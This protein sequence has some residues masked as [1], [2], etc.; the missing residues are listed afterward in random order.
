MRTC[1]RTTSQ[2][3]PVGLV[4][5]VRWEQFGLDTTLPFHAMW[6]TA[7][8]GTATGPLHAGQTADGAPRA[9]T[10]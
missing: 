6:Y 9:G 3:S 2:S 10:E 1:D 7:P 8:Q 4:D 5:V